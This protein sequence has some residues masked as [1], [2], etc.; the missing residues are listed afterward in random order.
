MKQALLLASVVFSAL[1]TNAQSKLSF[2]AT[3]G[4]GGNLCQTAALDPDAVCPSMNWSTEF[5]NGSAGS[6]AHDEYGVLKA[7]GTAAA[8]TCCAA[9]AGAAVSG[10]G[11]H[12]EFTDT[13]TI[14]GLTGPGPFFL[15]MHMNVVGSVSDAFLQGISSAEMNAINAVSG[16]SGTVECDLG[17]PT[18]LQGGF[19]QQCDS[20]LALT[21]VNDAVTIH[22]VL[23]IGANAVVPDT[24]GGNTQTVAID[25]I[26]STRKSNTNGARYLVFVEDSRGKKAARPI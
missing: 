26:G 23:S 3:S 22:G 10:A 20:K 24:T 18:N 5:F 1:C 7:G 4:G 8:T 16:Q 11:A 6:S 25:F 2:A 9:Q 14:T 17:G 12:A 21:G 15:V 13:L 19:N